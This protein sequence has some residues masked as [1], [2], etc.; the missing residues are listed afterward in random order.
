MSWQNTSEETERCRWESFTWGQECKAQAACTPHRAVTKYFTPAVHS[1]TRNAIHHLWYLLPSELGQLSSWHI[2]TLYISDVLMGL[3]KLDSALH[4]SRLIVLSLKFPQ[5]V[6]AYEVDCAEIHRSPAT[7]EEFAIFWPGLQGYD[8]T[9]QHLL[10]MGSYWK[11]KA[12]KSCSRLKYSV[13]S[14]TR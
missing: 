12:W 11:L 8:L 6:L 3:I 5:D 1:R 4:S 2:A 14:A 10:V 7:W 13:L 9:S